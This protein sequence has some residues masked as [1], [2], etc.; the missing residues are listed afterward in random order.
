MIHPQ[1]RRAALGGRWPMAVATLLLASAC[2]GSLP[3]AS[4]VR[5]PLGSRGLTPA[6]STGRASAY[7]APLTRRLRPDVMVTGPRTFSASALRRLTALARADG[8]VVMRAGQVR[9]SG[10]LVSTLGVDASSF[11]RFA[12]PGT[13]E[14][15][16]LWRVVASGQAVSSH[17]LAKGLGLPLA[18]PLLPTPSAGGKAVALRL[19]AYATSGLPASDLVVDEA[20]A[21]ELGL[22]PATGMVLTAAPGTDPVDL[23]AR[24]RAITGP[25]AAVDLLSPP[26][27]APTAFLTG[28]S[29]ASAFGAFSYRFSPDGT[30]EPD[31]AW[32]ASHIATESVPIFGLVTCHRL[33]FAQ[34]RGALTEVVAAGLASTLHTYDGC[35]VPKLIERTR[36]ISLH[37]WGIAIDLDARTN[38]RGTRGTMDPRVV[39]IFK[40]WGFRWGGD[41]S[42]TDPMHFELAALLGGAR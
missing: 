41:W 13:A 39:A 36:S 42:W 23:A 40:R 37:T 19:G 10:H 24:V 31:A 6:V 22:A 34:L 1:A 21:A 17:Q 12:A 20:R 27:D 3:P 18:A 32:V 7:V 38:G 25:A 28:S 16:A 8:S 4:A 14:S 5:A 9:L 11:R 30:L 33:M 29:A 35:Y 2:S 15:D 26:A